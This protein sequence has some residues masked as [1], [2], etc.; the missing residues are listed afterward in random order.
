MEIT[1]EKQYFDEESVF[2]QE[3]RVKS[4]GVVWRGRVRAN[5]LISVSPE[6]IRSLI[7][8]SIADASRGHEYIR[9]GKVGERYR[10]EVSLKRSK[11]LVFEN[12]SDINIKIFDSDGLL[13]ISIDIVPKDYI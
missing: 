3:F 12:A 6:R 7:A 13:K 11:K 10:Y 4:R 2:N 1:F 8:G 5:E 9:V